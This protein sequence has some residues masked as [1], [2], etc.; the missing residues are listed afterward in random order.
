MSFPSLAASSAVA[1]SPGARRDEGGGLL[2]HGRVFVG[3]LAAAS[4]ALG[5]AVQAEGDADSLASTS[6]HA[7]VRVARDQ[8]AADDRTTALSAFVRLKAGQ[9]SE[10]LLALT[11]PELGMPEAAGCWFRSQAHAAPEA[12]RALPE[13]L[14]ADSVVLSVE[15]APYELAPYAFPRVGDQM[16][17]ALY[18]SRRLPAPTRD[19]P[20][21]Y[22]LLVRGLPLEAR[23]AADQ[24]AIFELP[25]QVRDITISGTPFET[26]TTL[27]LSSPVDLTWTPGE[28]SPEESRHPD[29]VIVSVESREQAL[30]C[31]FAKTDAAGSVNESLLR[32]F[33]GGAPLS[34]SVRLAGVRPGEAVSGFDSLRVRFDA[35]LSRTVTAMP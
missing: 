2:L 4:L 30:S 8:D 22:R 24:E 6:L 35:T 12:G 31:A 15:G 1:A 3:A 10:D 17:G 5:C 9:E 28:L 18:S 27:S 26:L 33:Q 14:L 34:V 11:E 20:V 19:A 16:G 7:L 25:A 23:P 13:F 21:K 29:W 32:D